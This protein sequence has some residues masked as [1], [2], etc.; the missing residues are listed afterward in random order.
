MVS[1]RLLETKKIWRK[2]PFACTALNGITRRKT[3]GY[4]SMRIFRKEPRLYRMN[5][6]IAFDAEYALPEWRIFDNPKPQ[7]IDSKLG[8]VQPEVAIDG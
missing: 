8:R 7:K 1:G 6:V 4:L 5:W 2:R 3:T